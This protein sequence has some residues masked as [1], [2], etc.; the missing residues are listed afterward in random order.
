MTAQCASFRA[1]WDRSPAVVTLLG[2][3][4]LALASAGLLRDISG[5]SA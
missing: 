4:G 3:V 5:G 2:A 1:W